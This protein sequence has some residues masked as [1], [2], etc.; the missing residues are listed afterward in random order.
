MNA[1]EKWVHEQA[2][3]DERAGIQRDKDGWR[4]LAWNAALDAAAAAA[5]QSYGAPNLDK[6]RAP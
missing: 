1:Y 5:L 6:L 4:R 2:D 3:A